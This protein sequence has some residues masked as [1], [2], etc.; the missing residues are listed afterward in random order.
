M[1]VQTIKKIGNCTNVCYRN[2]V[3]L[4]RWLSLAPVKFDRAK[5]TRLQLRVWMR[6][7]KPLELNVLYRAL[8]RSIALSGVH[9]YTDS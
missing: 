7:S 8:G 1:E 4:I 2:R 9:R 6:L 3:D 5:V